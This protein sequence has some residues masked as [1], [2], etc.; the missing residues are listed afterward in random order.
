[1]SERTDDA[2]WQ[3]RDP[4]PEHA[5]AIAAWSTSAAEADVWA[6]RAEHPFP[7]AAIT[8]WWDDDDVSPWVLLDP[9]GHLVAYGEIWDDEEEDEVELA[10][11]IVDPGRR[12]EGIGRRLVDALVTRMRA[13]GRAACFLRVAPSNTAALALYRASGFVDVAAA[14]AAEWNRGQPVTYVWLTLPAAG[15]TTS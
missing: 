5:A 2:G 6:S 7:S 8:G 3:F 10:R 9:D 12:R 14:S 11:L 4:M 13:G 1:M 15:P